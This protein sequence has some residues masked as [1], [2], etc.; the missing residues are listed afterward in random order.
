MKSIKQ[1]TAISAALLGIAAAAPASAL[2]LTYIEGTIIPAQY[3]TYGDGNSYSLPVLALLYDAINGGGTGPGNPYYIASGVGQIKDLTVIGT[4]ASGGPVNTN[5]S[6]MDNAYP[7]PNSD[8]IEFF[9]TGTTVDPGQVSPFV[10]DQANTWDIRLTA[11]DGF[12]GDESPVFFFN[13]NQTNSGS[14]EDQN[15]AIWAALTLYDDADVLSPLTLYF[16]NLGGAYALI[17]EGG[18]GVLN[19]TAGSGTLGAPTGP[20]AGDNTSTD[21][22]LS[23]GALCYDATPKVVSCDDPLAVGGPINHNLGANQAVYAVVF[24]ALNDILALADFDGYDVLSIDWRMGC[25]PNTDQSEFSCDGSEGNHGRSLND[26]YEQ[27]FIGTVTSVVNVPE[28]ATL[29]LL[30][31]A[32]LGFA[33]MRRRKA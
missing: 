23:G 14:A 3:V 31:S 22:V 1:I 19:G 4:G 25:D 12:V 15:L 9:S 30:G 10:G 5:F 8:G 24:P 7:T 32:L 29:A 6:G 21:Y 2:D 13:N 11:L 17:S 26:G 27:L 16:S 33:A 20:D 28:P 18:G